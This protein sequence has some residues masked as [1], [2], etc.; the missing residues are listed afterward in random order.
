M[1]RIRE[2]FQFETV[3]NINNGCIILFARTG[4]R[5]QVMCNR[6]GYSAKELDVLP[7]AMPQI[8]HFNRVKNYYLDRKSVV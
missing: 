4:F 2:P 7:S 5:D 8:F 6:V 1:G 3:T